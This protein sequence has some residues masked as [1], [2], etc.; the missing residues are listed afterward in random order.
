MKLF[1]HMLQRLY[2]SLF[3]TFV[4]TYQ[5]FRSQ[6][7]S[8]PTRQIEP[9][10]VLASSRDFE[11]LTDLSPAASKT[12]M[13]AKTGLV[14]E[15]NGLILFKIEQFFLTPGE[16][17]VHPYY[18][19]EDRHSQ[20]FSDCNPGN[21]TNIGPVSL[22]TLF[23]TLS[24]GGLP[25]WVHPSQLSRDQI[26]EGVFPS[27]V[28]VVS[29]RLTSVESAV[30]A[31]AEVSEMRLLPGLIRESNLPGSFDLAQTKYLSVP[32]AGPPKPAIRQQFSIQ[33]MPPELALPW[34]IIFLGLHQIALYLKL[35]WLKHN[36]Y[37][38]N[39]QIFST[40][41]LVRA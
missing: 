26:P 37:F 13:Q 7:W 38:V 34:L 8:Y 29:L 25:E 6:Q 2:K 21:A 40:L 24:S 17:G 33:S 9:L 18:E 31:D 20:L 39:V 32:D 4:S 28:S 15:N 16:N 3:I 19:L 22:S 5:A 27:L 30:L 1:Q 41:V 35:S 12:W 14:L 11:S 10:A 23:H 36:I